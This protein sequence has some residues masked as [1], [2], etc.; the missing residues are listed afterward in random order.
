MD[1]LPIYFKFF[2]EIFRHGEKTPD[3]L[4]SYPNDPY[5]NETYYPYGLGQLTKVQKK[6]KQHLIMRIYFR[7]GNTQ[8]INLENIYSIDINILSEAH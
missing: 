4:S 8:C 3:R 7:K 1:N 2:L 6:V 5:L